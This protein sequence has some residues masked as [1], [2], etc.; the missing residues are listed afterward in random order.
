MTLFLL[1]IVF[2]VAG[3]IIMIRNKFYKTSTKTMLF[4]AEIKLFMSGLIL[5]L[6]GIYV[7]ISEILKFFN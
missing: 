4:P 3:V 5:F 7:L 1:G 2:I 6:M